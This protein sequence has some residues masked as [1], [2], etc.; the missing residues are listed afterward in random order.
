MGLVDIKL[1]TKALMKICGISVASYI[2][3]YA[4]IILTLLVY[5]MKLYYSYKLSKTPINDVQEY[6]PDGT[7]KKSS[8][9]Y[10]Q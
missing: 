2:N 8:K 7:L 6:F 3:V 1:L 10:R 9:K 4:G 5:A